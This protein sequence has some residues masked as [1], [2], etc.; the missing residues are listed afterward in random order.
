MK[1]LKP[2]FIVVSILLALTFVLPSLLV[3]P[4]AKEKDGP[5]LSEL[6]QESKKVVDSSKTEV[7]VF[8]NATETIETLPLEEYV[9]GVV[10]SEMPAEF[11]IEALKAQAL[12]A[13]TYITN[14]LLNSS[15]DKSLP[16]GANIT[17][18]V[19]HQVFK[20]KEELKKQWGKDFEKKYKKITEA[21]QATEG[22]ILT[23]QDK[24]ITAS[25][26]STG[27]G[28][29]ENSEEYWE[30]KIPYLKSVESPWD[31]QAPEFESK[32]TLSVAEFEE[33]LGVKISDSKDIGTITGRTTGNKVAAV[34]INDKTF[35]GREI[36]EKLDLRSTHFTWQRN[37][38]S[39]IITT[40]GYGHG[41]GMSQYG[42]N[43]MAKEGKNYRDIVEH[44][45]KD[46]SI[47]KANDFMDKKYVSK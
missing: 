32:K 1:P 42:A 14:Y 8:R 17:D 40:K 35:T 19:N 24:P 39:V 45:Y 12:A 2:L 15:E 5:H 7:A 30:N 6:K 38:N 31:T 3:L 44:Y 36:R 9:V 27:N 10:A 16:D 13:R 26:F 29:T 43:G 18:T 22:E 21:V 34:K 33:K 37:G 4:S 46:V 25:F 41:V 11:E 47:T 20:N 28:F 23:Y